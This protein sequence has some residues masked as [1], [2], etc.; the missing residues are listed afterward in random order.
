M[1]EKERERNDYVIKFLCGYVLCIIYMQVMRKD[2]GEIC[3]DDVFYVYCFMFC[4]FWCCIVK[5]Y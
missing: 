1:R 5:E 2:G 4:G 3:K